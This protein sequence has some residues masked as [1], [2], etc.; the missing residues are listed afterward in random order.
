LAKFIIYWRNN[1]FIGEIK[2]EFS[3]F[4]SFSSVFFIDKGYL[5]QI[6]AL[7]FFEAST[8]TYHRA[9]HRI[10]ETDSITKTE[11]PKQRTTTSVN[12]AVAG[13]HKLAHKWNSYAIKYR[14]NI[15]AQHNNND[16]I[17]LN[18]NIKKEKKQNKPK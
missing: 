3:S 13:I 6:S 16:H 4:Y 8:S 1:V 17:I 10:K 11:E 14:Y 9:R 12:G 15:K 5:K 7:T 2:N 18:I